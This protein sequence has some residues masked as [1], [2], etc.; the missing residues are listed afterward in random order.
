MDCS[1]LGSSVHGILQERILEW[2]AISF[3]RGSSKPGIKSRSLAL[4][5]DSLPTE[6]WGKPLE[7][8]IRYFFCGLIKACRYIPDRLTE[9]VGKLNFSH[10]KV[11]VYGFI[12][13]I[14]IILI[15]IDIT[16]FLFYKIKE[17]EQLITW[18][19]NPW[20]L[21]FWYY[22]G[23]WVRISLDLLLSF[24]FITEVN[25]TLELPLASNITAQENL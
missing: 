18:R 11:T 3:S 1:L 2:V 16:L 24:L 12:V 13:L 15:Y 22:L 6:L 23:S 10:R 25:Q 9:M 7:R 4:Q 20:K 21:L 14:K 17:I 8:H 5:T 19:L